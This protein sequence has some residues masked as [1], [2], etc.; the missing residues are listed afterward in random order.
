M[1]N[2]AIHRT[3]L[4]DFSAVKVLGKQMKEQILTP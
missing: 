3:G 2:L 1:K 4:N